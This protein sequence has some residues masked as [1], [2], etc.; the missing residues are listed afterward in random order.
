[1]DEEAFG[2]LYCRLFPKVWAYAVSR[3]GRQSAEDVVAEAFAVAW[4][5]RQDIPPDPLPWLLAV[6][7]NVIRETTRAEQRQRMLM[8]QVQRWL[9]AADCRG[10]DVAEGVVDRALV[11]AALASLP[12]ADQELL[13]LVAWHGLTAAAAAAALHCSRPALLMRLHRARK[14]LEVAVRAR[15][16]DRSGAAVVVLARTQPTEE[17]SP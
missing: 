10:D 8:A 3:V 13:V 17:M 16:G 6:A 2:I 9:L 14:R 5:R 12:E 15:S 11:L 1:M 7:R 4:R